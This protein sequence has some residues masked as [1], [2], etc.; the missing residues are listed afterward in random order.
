MAK[1]R[2]KKSAGGD[3]VTAPEF[4]GLWEDA[5]A[6][7]LSGRCPVKG[8][9]G[10]LRTIHDWCCSDCYEAGHAPKV[11]EQLEPM[12]AEAKAKAEQVPFP[13]LKKGAL[14]VFEAGECPVAGCEGSVTRN[15]WCCPNCY[16]RGWAPQVRAELESRQ[17]QSAAD[18]AA[19]GQKGQMPR[20]ALAPA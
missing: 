5:V 10:K 1:Q 16:R 9:K 6:R 14:R 2:V 11:K 17:V 19:N 3:P 7:Q 12:Q 4:P 8:C 13:G 15:Q 18:K 20:P